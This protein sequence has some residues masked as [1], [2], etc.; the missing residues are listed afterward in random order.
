[1]RTKKKIVSVAKSHPNLLQRARTIVKHYQVII[2]IAGDGFEG[3]GVEIP[4]ISGRGRT[5][6]ACVR[7]TRSA[8]AARVLEFLRNDQLPPVSLSGAER[9]KRVTIRVNALEKLLL[10]TKARQAGLRGVAEYVQAIA[11]SILIAP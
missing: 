3:Q 1:M 11:R 9:T 2:K 4:S 7:N 6:S 8:M 10:E 5:V